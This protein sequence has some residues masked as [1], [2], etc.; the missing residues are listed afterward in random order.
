MPPLP[1]HPPSYE[2]EP[3]I[4]E[5]IQTLLHADAASVNMHNDVILNLVRRDMQRSIQERQLHGRKFADTAFMLAMT[6][7]EQPEVFDL[8]VQGAIHEI[9]RCRAKRN[10]RAYDMIVMW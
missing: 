8:L 2:E 10:F 3:N 7:Y 1:Q 5:T 6:G 4:T 9:Q